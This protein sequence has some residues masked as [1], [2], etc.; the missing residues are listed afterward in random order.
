MAII[1]VNITYIKRSPT[2]ICPLAT[3]W[4]P[5]KIITNP[6]APITSDEKAEVAE[7]PVIDLAMLRNSL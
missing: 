2:V 5:T 7:T 1:P 3:E 4:P 6:I